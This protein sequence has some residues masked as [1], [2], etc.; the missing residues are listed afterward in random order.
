MAVENYELCQ[1]R[2][3]TC[4][5]VNR[6]EFQDQS[7]S[8]LHC[9]HPLG[10]RVVPQCV[11]GGYPS[12]SART[13][14]CIRIHSRRSKNAHTWLTDVV[15][16]QSVHRSCSSEKETSLGWRGW[17]PDGAEVESVTL[18]T[19]ARARI[20]ADARVHAWTLRRRNMMA[21]RGRMSCQRRGGRAPYVRCMRPATRMTRQKRK[22]CSDKF[23]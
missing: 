14:I 15:P 12:C 7:S 18:S 9:W 2:E 4:H 5:H 17:T 1:T 6:P 11:H 13:E 10:Y 21:A 20:I 19:A 3:T 23:L 22:P 8:C 16:A